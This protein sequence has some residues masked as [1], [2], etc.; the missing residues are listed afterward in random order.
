MELK[1]FIYLFGKHL[2]KT[3]VNETICIENWEG[4]DFDTRYIE[5][6]Q[7]YTKIKD[8]CLKLN[9]DD[10]LKNFKEMRQKILE[11]YYNKMQN[12]LLN[13]IRDEKPLDDAEFQEIVLQLDKEK[14][15][16][17]L[18]KNF[19]TNIREIEENLLKK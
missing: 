7:F 12:N 13:S 10:I 9:K 3:A 2:L 1:E 19:L 5:Y 17:E 4:K 6:C 8:K 14:D 18:N 16:N 15:L 11:K